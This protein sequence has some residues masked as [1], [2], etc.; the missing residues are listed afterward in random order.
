MIKA[1]YIKNFKSFYNETVLNLECSKND[2]FDEINTFTVGNNK[3]LKNILIYGA[4]ASGKSNLI[5]S[6]KLITDVLL[7]SYDSQ[8][9]LI[10]KIEPF[11]LKD[12]SEYMGTEFGINFIL[13]KIEYEYSFGVNEGKIVS[14]S[15][16]K[17]VNRKVP[18][19]ERSSPSFKDI[20]MSETHFKFTKDVIGNLRQDVLFLTFSAFLNNNTSSSIKCFFENVLF[21]SNNRQIPF[22]LMNKKDNTIDE[23]YLKVIQLADFNIKQLKFDSE[24][25]L[26]ALYDYYSK[27]NE[28]QGMVGLP[29]NSHSSKGTNHFYRIL[30]YM[31]YV[32]QN[33]GVFIIDEIDKHLHP[34]LTRIIIE[35][36][37][38]IEHNKGNAQ[39]ICT[40]HDVTLLDENIRRDQ[41]YFVNKNEFGE[42]ELYS[43]NDFK[44]VRKDNNTLKR[45]LLGQYGAVPK[46]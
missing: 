28:K 37:N 5:K 30:R 7:S 46:F 9:E 21:D 35:M 3:L 44:G 6:M 14:E 25:K 40:V 1:I 2:E 12:N 36:F 29:F 43:L 22:Y 19:F 39:L 8:S 27:D 17:K 13:D 15:L 34:I 11:L 45:Y 4:N 24:E 23:E 38:S 16:Y 20:S 33:G 32:L 10:K 42:S 31:L 41:I 26:I 18:L